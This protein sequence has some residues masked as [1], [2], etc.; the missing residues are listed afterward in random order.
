MSAGKKGKRHWIVG[1]VFVLRAA[2]PAYQ[3]MHIETY[4]LSQ[5]RVG[6]M[7][8]QM[9]TQPVTLLHDMEPVT[10]RYCYSATT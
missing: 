10:T 5:K 2:I 7:V 1:P 3:I 8:W 9:F 6:I 4:E